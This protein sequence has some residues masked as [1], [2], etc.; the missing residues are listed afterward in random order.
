LK[1][2]LV[3]GGVLDV[4]GSGKTVYFVNSHNKE[5]SSNVYKADM[6]SGEWGKLIQ[7]PRW[8]PLDEVAIDSN[9]ELYFMNTQRVKGEWSNKI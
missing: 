7:E 3:P 6:M 8:Y 4:K 5:N 1:E 9:Q 2:W